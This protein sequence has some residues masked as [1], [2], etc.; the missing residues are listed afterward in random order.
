MSKELDP[1]IKFAA[2]ISDFTRDLSTTYPEF[3][4]LWSNVITNDVNIEATYNHCLSVYPE[5]FFDILYQNAE[6]FQVDNPANTMFLPNV[7]FKMLYN[8]DGVTDQT[9]QTIWKY[10]QLILISV[11]SGVHD[12]SKFGDT[13][14]MFEGIDETEFQEKL[15]TMMEG[16]TDFFTKTEKESGSKTD[17]N[18]DE[19]EKAEFDSDLPKFPDFKNMFDPSQ[20]QDLQNHLKELFDGKIGQ[21]AREM[22]EEISQEMLEL[23]DDGSGDIKTTADVINKMMKNPKKMMELLKKVGDKLEK[24]MDSGEISKEEMMK[25]AAD[26][27]SKFKEMGADNGKLGEM[28][29]TMAASMGKSMGKGAKFDMNAMSR[30]TQQESTKDRLRNKLAAN[31]ARLAEKI[32]AKQAELQN[33]LDQKVKKEQDLKTLVEQGII[34]PTDQPDNYVFHLDGEETQEKSSRPNSN[35]SKNKKSKKGKK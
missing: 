14:N 21:M 16:L 8:L 9:K 13:A 3:T 17:D 2:I 18:T 7:E 34:K 10:L 4:Y 25:E 19:S 11:M 12:K 26:I 28:M 29:K 35:V 23:L 30:M 15:N 5:R 32:Q 6:I 22:S 27:M 1:K 31:K 24:K 33:E 20:M